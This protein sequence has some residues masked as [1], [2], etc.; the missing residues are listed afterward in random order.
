MIHN[1]ICN[2]IH[3][4]IF[5]IIKHDSKGRAQIRNHLINEKAQ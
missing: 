4:K 5:Y 3:K 2:L 1:Y